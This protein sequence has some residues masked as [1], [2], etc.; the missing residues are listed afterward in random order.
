MKYDEFR[1]SASF[2]QQEL[3]AFA[4]GR[5]VEDPPEAFEAKLPLPPMLMLDRIVEISRERNRGRIV[6]ERD[7]R[8]DDWFFQ[9]HFLGDPVQPGCLG[10]D[11][12]WQLLG[13]FCAWAGGLG[14][15][16]ALGCGE[17]EFS[18]QIR[19]HDTVVRYEI[20]IVRYQEL[21][22]L[23]LLGG[24]SATPRSPSTVSRSTTSSGPRSASSATSTTP[25]TRCPR[26][27]PAAGGWANDDFGQGPGPPDAGS[28][29]GLLPQQEPFRFIDEILELDDEHI[30]GG[31]PLSAG[32][33]LLPRPLPRQPGHA[34]RD[35]DRGDGPGRR[36]GP[37]HLP[38]SLRTTPRRRS[39]GQ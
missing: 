18:G 10:V 27:T 6:A 13:F 36:R 4:H 1:G 34:G 35:P 11:G 12:V 20:D 30:V 17:V 29:A 5:L 23:G 37:R 2:D 24:R 28:G 3:L 38:A 14:T 15:G 39:S 19:P 33:R 32:G 26:S 7:V 16:R 8:L 25:T 21:P 22:S 31:L 9:C